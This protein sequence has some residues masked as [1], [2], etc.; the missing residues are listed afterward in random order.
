[1]E[2][3]TD[4]SYLI[5]KLLSLVVFWGVFWGAMCIVNDDVMKK[6]IIILG[7]VTSIY[8]MAPKL[9]VIV[10][11]EQGCVIQ[12]LWKKSVYNWEDFKII[13]EEIWS[14]HETREWREGII[15]SVKSFNPKW[16]SDW[17]ARNNIYKSRDYCS[18]FY[19]IFRTNPPKKFGEEYPVDREEFFEKMKEWN[20]PI[21]RARD[22]EKMRKMMEKD[23]KKKNK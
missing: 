12:W 22:L 8:E 20:V 15:F 5:K 6:F 17:N 7:I 16:Q 2:I 1:M 9:R 21:T 10:I 23:N 13:R 18:C 11:N 14:Y 4:K 19:V 3:K